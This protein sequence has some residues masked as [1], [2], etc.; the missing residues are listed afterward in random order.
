MDKKEIAAI[1]EEIGALLDLKGENPF[2][3]RAYY[4]AARMVDGLQED[5]SKLVEE[6][7]LTEIKG[8]GK[9]LAAK[10]TEMVT[11][12]HLKFYDEL[13]ASMPQGLLDMLK[14]PGFGPKRAKIVYEKLKID[15]IEKLEAAC[16][17]GKIAQ[18]DGFGEKSQQKILEGIVLVKQFGDRH[19]YD[20]ARAVADPIL[21]ALRGHDGVIRCSIAGA[22]AGAG[23]PSA[24]SIF[25]SAP[26]RRMRRA[27]SRTLPRCP[28]SSACRPKARPKPA[29]CSRAGS[30]PTCAL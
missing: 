2:R 10:I 12:N 26:S 17:A 1:F 30:R 15:S 21:E 20:K 29:L 7:R 11:T 13:K 25:W 5:L 27:S 23:K 6:N 24:T 18:L 28:A 4:N 22:C 9:D 8:I 14:I 19:H 16:K 3:V